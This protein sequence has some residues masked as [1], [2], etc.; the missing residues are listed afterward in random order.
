VDA[1]DGAGGRATHLALRCRDLGVGDAFLPLLRRGANISHLDGAGASVLDLLRERAWE[2]LGS[3]PSPLDSGVPEGLSEAADAAQTGSSHAGQRAE[4]GSA[5]EALAEAIAEV[6]HCSLQ[7]RLQEAAAQQ[8][9][10]VEGIETGLRE[11]TAKVDEMKRDIEAALQKVVPRMEEALEALD[12]LEY[13]DLNRMRMLTQ[14]PPAVAQVFAAVCHVLGVGPER[15]AEEAPSSTASRPPVPVSVSLGGAD[16]SSS[17]SPLSYEACLESWPAS[18]KLLSVGLIIQQIHCFDKD[19]IPD[20]TIARL[21]PLQAHADLDPDGPLRDSPAGAALALWLR[22]LV[23][24]HEAAALV[25]PKKESFQELTKLLEAQ[26]AT[27]AE[28][29]RRLQE[30]QATAKDSSSV[31]R[32]ALLKQ[33]PSGSI[34]ASLPDK[35]RDVLATRGQAVREALQLSEEV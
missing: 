32:G 9:V 33:P 14:P 7:L 16:T 19:R 35:G 5:V 27:L 10:V 29:L 12:R 1:E 28:E 22:A 6:E 2:A 4:G 15:P 21:R 17:V 26:E 24:Y 34:V 31:A 23:S 13:E 8:C 11:A 3:L 30:L 20:A 18:Q 25:A